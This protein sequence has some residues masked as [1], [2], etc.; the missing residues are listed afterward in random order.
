[1]TVGT[2][3]KD[4]YTAGY[5]FWM[6][7]WVPY[8]IFLA[9]Q[10]WVKLKHETFL[11][12]NMLNHTDAS[13]KNSNS[14]KRSEMLSEWWGNSLILDTKVLSDRKHYIKFIGIVMLISNLTLVIFK[15]WVPTKTTSFYMEYAEVFMINIYMWFFV[16]KDPKI[17]MMSTVASILVLNL[18]NFLYKDDKDLVD[19]LTTSINW[20]ISHWF[21]MA[22]WQKENALHRVLYF[23]SMDKGKIGQNEFL[24]MLMERINSWWNFELLSDQ[25]IDSLYSEGKRDLNE[26]RRFEDENPEVT[27]NFESESRDNKKF[28]DK[29]H[30]MV[31]NEENVEEEIGAK[32]LLIDDEFKK[33]YEIKDIVGDSIREYSIKI[34]PITFTNNQK[35]LLI[36]FNDVSEKLRLKESKIS[37]W[38]KTIMLWSI[39]HELRSPVNQING[40]LSL[41]QPT[42]KT[43][44]QQR[45]LKIANSSNEILRIKISDMLDYYEI[46]TKSFK[47][48][49]VKFNPREHLKFLESLF[50]CL[51]D[52]KNVKLYFFVHKQTPKYIYHDS[53]RIIQILVNLLSNAIKY[54]KK[55]AILVIVDWQQTGRFKHKPEG[56]IKFTVSD[57]GWG[58]PKDKKNNLFKFLDFSQF[59]E[60]FDSNVDNINP[61]NTKLAGTGL[62]ISQKI[63][64]QLNSEIEVNSIVGAGSKFY[65]HLE[66][67]TVKESPIFCPFSYAYA[68]RKKRMNLE[69]R[70]INVKLSKTIVNPQVNEVE[71]KN[72]PR[73][74]SFSIDDG[75]LNAVKN[76]KKFRFILEPDI[77]NKLLFFR[78][79][80]NISHHNKNSYTLVDI[81]QVH[82][83]SKV[84]KLELS[85]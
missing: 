26:I 44:E 15:Q 25:A 39:S 2:K 4:E 40:M 64:K 49:I 22:Y 81:D 77:W 53:K 16:L 17:W 75:N 45:L 56:I 78:N 54:T 50:V 82:N 34:A 51:I 19:N 79:Y 30:F 84:I 71:I 35:S 72:A 8:T 38:M 32:D 47:T 80:E 69:D 73:K 48:E 70:E 31:Y 27:G 5:H 12:N 14:D 60:N 9:Y 65:F 36:V 20:W 37:D 13:E 43:S 11:S 59:K 66:T 85:N 57:S 1:M 41:L 6:F 68:N 58:I 61:S 28:D 10:L 63:A 24:K 21:F 3:E 83:I 7:A 29:L 23:T 62:G 74:R 67:S 76:N 55:G 33:N 52:K 46:E 42:L 18:Y